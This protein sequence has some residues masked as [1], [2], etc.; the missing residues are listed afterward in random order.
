VKGSC[1][2]GRLW[3]ALR[4]PQVEK[5]FLGLFFGWGLDG[6]VTVEVAGTVW[7]CWHLDCC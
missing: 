1:P 2:E 5:N 4:L 7:W 3:G 6:D